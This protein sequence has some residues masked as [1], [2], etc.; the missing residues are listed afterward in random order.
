[1]YKWMI[2]CLRIQQGECG[3][4]EWA[5]Q[6]RLSIY[7]HSDVVFFVRS[8]F[9]CSASVKSGPLS[10]DQT[11]T[12]SSFFSLCKTTKM[13]LFRNAMKSGSLMRLACRN[14]GMPSSRDFSAVSEQ[15]I[16]ELSV[17]SFLR[18]PSTGTHNPRLFFFLFTCYLRVFVG[19]IFP[20]FVQYC[21]L[22]SLYFSF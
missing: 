5:L 13:S 18:P 8:I 16:Q 19:F 15:P 21:T 11:S 14:Q 4:N 17:D 2:I 20:Q 7:P 10:I 3:L 22:T 12:F 6:S 9:C 1:M